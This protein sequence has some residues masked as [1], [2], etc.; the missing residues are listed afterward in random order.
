MRALASGQWD[1]CTR[2]FT[3]ALA[4]LQQTGKVNIMLQAKYLL[5]LAYYYQ[6]TFSSPLCRNLIMAHIYD[7]ITG[8]IGWV[9]GKFFESSGCFVSMKQDTLRLDG[10]NVSQ[11]LFYAN[12]GQALTLL[13]FDKLEE[14]QER[15][16]EASILFAERYFRPHC[17]F[18]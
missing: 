7:N 5:G 4:I 18:T 13:H 3:A 10:H 6:G 1:E 15:F 14:A 16:E 8:C 2:T 12:I 9:I 11:H 17:K